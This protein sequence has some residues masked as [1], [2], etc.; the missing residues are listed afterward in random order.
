MA[1]STFGT[2]LT[3]SMTAMQFTGAMPQADIATI[4]AAII[5]DA[6]LSLV[7]PGAW[8]QTGILYVPNRGIL[9]AQPGD[10]VAVDSQGWPILVSK[11]S[12]ANA[13]WTHNP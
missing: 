13:A 8:A 7:W 1:T 9:K 11:N 12:I 2:T 10:W 3:T 6:D 5:N 4:Q